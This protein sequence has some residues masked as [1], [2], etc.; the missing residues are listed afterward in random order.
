MPA[1]LPIVGTFNAMRPKLAS[2][3]LVT[4]LAL[5][6][7]VVAHAAHT[8]PG[9]A[10]PG[11][12]RAPGAP[13]KT[14]SEL[15][16]ST[17]APAPAEEPSSAVETE[18]EERLSSEAEA[19]EAAEEAAVLHRIEREAPTSEGEPLGNASAPGGALCLVPSL[20]GDTLRAARRALSRAHCRLG[21]ITEPRTRHAKLTVTAQSRPAGARLADNAPVA[22]RLLATRRR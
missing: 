15:P 8:T 2:I 13:L 11:E 20:K 10:A 19:L 18:D 22:V 9:A 12:A 3:V 14:E 6:A 16:T 5:A 21:R 7:P 4:L 1:A 17:S